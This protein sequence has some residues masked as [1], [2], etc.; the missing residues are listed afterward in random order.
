MRKLWKRSL[1]MFLAVLMVVSMLPV[2]VLAAEVGSTATTTT[3]NAPTDEPYAVWV[4]DESTTLNPNPNTTCSKIE[5]QHSDKCYSKECD[6]KNAT[7]NGHF[8]SCYGVEWVLCTHGTNDSNAHTDAVT[9][10]ASVVDSLKKANAELWSAIKSYCGM[11]ADYEVWKLIKAYGKTFC[12]TIDF[13]NLTCNHVCSE[14]GGSCYETSLLNGCVGYEH[15]HDAGENGCYEYTWTLKAD[16]NNNEIA[17]D[18]DTRYEVS[19]NLN[20][21]NGAYDPQ[22]VLTGMAATNVADPTRTGYTFVGWSPALNTVI[23]ADTEFVAQWDADEY[24]ITWKNEDG[25]LYTTTKADYD[26]TPVA[27][28]APEKADTVEWDYSFA[29]WIPELHPVNGQD[30]YTATYSE[31]KQQYTITFLNADGTVLQSSKW[32]YGTTPVYAGEVPT[33]DADADKTYTF[34]G[35]DSQISTVKGEKTY[36][37]TFTDKNLYDI[38]FVQSNGQADITDKVEE[39]EVV[40]VPEMDPVYEGYRFIGWFLDEAGTTPFVEG[41]VTKDT[42]IYAGWIKQYTVTFV[43]ANFEAPESITADVNTKIADPGLLGVDDLTDDIVMNGWYIEG[44]KVQFPY[45]IISDVIM[46]ARWV[47]DVDNDGLEDGSDADPFWSIVYVDG[48]GNEL[49]KELHLDGAQ[50][51]TIEDPVVEGYTFMGWDIVADEFV[52]K[53]VIYTATWIADVNQNGI[54]DKFEVITVVV[55]NAVESDN[56]TVNGGASYIYDSVAGETVTIVA[57]PTKNEIGSSESYVASIVV[58]DGENVVTADGYADDFSYTYELVLD[59]V[60]GPFNTAD[61]SKFVTVTFEACGFTYDEDGQMR[62]Y[63]G[64]E[65]PD[66]ETLYNAVI[67]EPVYD[68]EKVK[69]VEYLARPAGTYSFDIPVIF[70]WTIPLINRPIKLGGNTYNVD[71]E[72]A[73]LDVGEDF[74]TL[75]ED[76]LQMKLDVEIQKIQAKISA[77]DLTNISWGNVWGKLEQLTAIGEELGTLADVIKNEAK[78]LG[79]HEFG[80]AGNVEDENGNVQEILHVV[81]ETEAMRLEDD[82]VIVTLVD[83][84][85][86][87]T[88]EGGNVTFEYDEYT[89]ADIMSAITLVDAD[90]NVIEGDVYKHLVLEGKNV[91]E[92]TYNVYYDGSYD[93]KPAKAEFVLTVIKAPSNTDVPNID[94]FYGESYDGNPV[95]TNKHDE[96]VD[97]DSIRF[98]LGLDVAEF[99]IDEDGVKGLEG[100]VQLLI[101]EELQTILSIVGLENGATMSL[102]DMVD[103][104]SSNMTLLENWGLTQEIVDAIQTVMD[105]LTNIVEAGNLEITIGGDYPVNVGAYLSGAVVVDANYDTSFDVGYIL[106]KP[107]ATQVYLDFNYAESNIFTWELLQEVDLGTTAYDDEELTISNADVTEMIYNLYF[108]VDE[109]GELVYTWDETELGNGAYAQLAFVAEFGNELYYAVPIARAFMILPEISGV[110]LVDAEGNAEDS[111]AYIFD[112]TEKDLYVAV[113]GE[114]VEAEIIY[115]GIQLNGEA[116]E[117]TTVA[118]KNAGA[119]VATVV[120]TPRNEAGELIAAGFDAA[121][122][123]IEPAESTIT[124]TGDEIVYDGDGHTVKVEAGSENSTDAA[125]TLISGTVKLNGSVNEIGLDALEGNVNVDFPAWLDTLLTE[126]FADAYAN[127]IVAKD[128]VTKL[129]QYTDAMVELGVSEDMIAEVIGVIDGIPSTLTL[130]FTDNKLYSESGT[131]FYY[132]IVTDFNYIPSADTGVMVITLADSE[133]V[134]NDTTVTWDGEEHFVDVNNPNGCDYAYVMIDRENNIGNIVLEDDL[135]SI[136]T[137]LE[138]TFGRKLPTEFNVTEFMGLVNGTLDILDSFNHLP[139]RAEEVLNQIKEVVA[140]LPQSGMIY[141]NGNNPS[142][143]GTYEFYGIAGSVDYAPTTTKAVLEIVPIN[144]EVIVDNVSKVYGDADPELTYMVKYLDHEGNEIVADKL[145]A[146]N[147]VAVTVSREAGENVGYYGITAEVTMNDPVYYALVSVTE[148]AQMEIKPAELIVTVDAQTKVYG[149]TDPELTYT[150]DGLKSGDDESVLNIEISREPGENVGVYAITATAANDNYII[151]ITNST[152]TITQKQITVTAVNVEKVYGDEDPEFTAQIEGLVGEETLNVTFTRVEGENVGE[153]T[154]VPSVAALTRNALVSNYD[155]IYVDGSLKI[156]PAPLTITLDNLTKV[157]GTEDAELTYTVEGLKFNEDAKD[158][159]MIVTSREDG[160]TVGSYA[161]DASAVNAVNPNYTITVVEGEYEITKKSI[162]VTADDQIKYYGDQ[163]P[164]FTAQIEGLV[165]E[166]SLKVTFTREEGADVDEYTIIPV[167]SQEDNADV[168]GNYDI[169]YVNGTL[170]IKPADVWVIPESVEVLAGTT[171]PEVVYEVQMNLGNVDLEELGIILK[172]NPEYDAFGNMLPGEYQYGIEYNESDNWIVNF[173]EAHLNVT[174]GDYVCWNVNTGV[175]YNDVSDALTLAKFGEE[176]EMLKNTVAQQTYVADALVEDETAYGKD[177]IVVIVGNGVTFDLNGFYVETDNLLSFGTVIDTAEDT[178]MDGIETG[179]IL[180]SNNTTEAWTQLQPEN[181]GY[182]PV[183]DMETGS[184]KFFKGYIT[185]HKGGVFY[186]TATSVQF[187]FK[188]LFDNAEGY[189]VL[190]RTTESNLDVIMDISWTGISNLDIEYTMSDATIRE[191]GK[192]AFGAILQTGTH[193]K[194]IALKVYGLD[195][196]GSGG[197]ITCLPTFETVSGV[198]GDT[199]TTMNYNIP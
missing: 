143:I 72:D 132:G 118:P 10:D 198:I 145:P 173:D 104:L 183:Y 84:R 32:E 46:T 184:Y 115:T 86:A 141:L 100:K 146:A 7:V 144:V 170:E 121:V 41:T 49:Y 66:Y 135:S 199:G 87:A 122:I 125:V 56:A 113:K 105:S 30:V 138:K 196:I 76:E 130:T 16:I 107:V 42:V 36:T 2:N 82:N 160:E 53:D 58:S 181:G 78:Y 5:H 114:I 93:Y 9:I 98:I 89:D 119:Y 148:D 26:S 40:K 185:N 62:F 137:I 191:Y 175:Y 153:Y 23:T 57:T 70:E 108:G 154:I 193:N 6:H 156:I 150:V 34:A 52:T 68:V 29:G 88:I 167:A 73:W 4:L 110:E 162:T 55:N 28:E 14:V 22:S 35:W 169:E 37:A 50:M 128:L 60:T 165:G 1:S 63:T 47:A 187:W 15:T 67:T 91:G 176:V 51:P 189:Q 155:I 43:S 96:V 168:I 45:T 27:P 116:Y 123:T 126:R 85:A 192:Q 142:E 13:N 149:D 65:T 31:A 139:A 151:K 90:G 112:D 111:Y 83:D 39:D 134:M 24:T 124:V 120:Y 71:L 81:Y 19:F 171:V 3:E 152:L 75:T 21:G 95:I 97:A 33:K 106:I 101:P 180:I 38:T 177:E 79:F 186:G 12:Y 127:G 131:Y 64:I 133:L 188:I 172:W 174:L 158:V 44:E 80:Q 159:L 61:R 54:E 25:T 74:D 48:F 194:G 129:R 99:D 178:T 195:R 163:D 18:V 11:K 69:V 166:D 117:P 102:D 147:T 136:V 197:Y 182:I 59:A 190:G 92:Y 109:Q 157:Y 179:G 161:I 8:Q 94:I 140:Q 17:D 77:I 20:G 164:T 103:F